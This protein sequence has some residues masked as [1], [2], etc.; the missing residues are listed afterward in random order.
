MSI[1]SD[2]SRDRVFRLSESTSTTILT[3]GD[4]TDGR[5]DFT[6][7]YQAAGARTSLHMHTRYDE[8]FW[9]VEG[10]LHVWAGDEALTLRSGDYY[11]VRM[12]TQHALQAGPTGCR[13][14]Q[15]S[16]PAGFAEL[17]SRVG[18][19]ERQVE[20]GIEFDPER[21][22]RVATELGDVQ[23]GPPG[24]LPPRSRS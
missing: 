6:D 10:S 18:I 4:E 14:L 17:I 11:V 16:S 22:L 15:I 3:F 7:T 2:E 9:V 5:H 8:R 20:A 13:A 23:L 19:P 21:F 24:A 12:G 1:T